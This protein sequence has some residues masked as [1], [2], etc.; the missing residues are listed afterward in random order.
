MESTH[1]C[2][3]KLENGNTYKFDCDARLLVVRDGKEIEV[4]ADEL[5][6]DDDMI[7]DNRDLVW[8]INNQGNEDNER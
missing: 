7:F 1:Y 8:T 3:I 6:P 2:E 4:Y 5:Q